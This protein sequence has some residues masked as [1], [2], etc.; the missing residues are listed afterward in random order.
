MPQK[1]ERTS[2]I[3]SFMELSA[4]TKRPD[5]R[6]LASTVESWKLLGY[7]ADPIVQKL[8]QYKTLKWE[9]I[10]NFYESRMKNKPTAYIIVG[11]K[12]KIDMNELAKYGKVVEIK[13][14]TLFT[15]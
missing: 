3:Q 7:T 1:T 11:D 6:K 5:R 10:N 8:P 15:K 14:N 12:K 13:E 4:Q 9:T 2:M